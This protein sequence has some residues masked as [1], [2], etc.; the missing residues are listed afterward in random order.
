M[1]AFRAVIVGFVFGISLIFDASAYAK[2]VLCRNLL[3][4]TNLY[5]SETEITNGP[6]NNIQEKG[7]LKLVTFN[8]LQLRMVP[9]EGAFDFGIKS[10]NQIFS[11]A[12][13]VSKTDPDILFLQEV[14]GSGTVSQI[15]QQYWKDAFQ[16]FKT[17]HARGLEIQNVIAVKKNLLAHYDFEHIDFGRTTWQDPNGEQALSPIFQREPL[18]VTMTK[19]SVGPRGPPD[20]VFVNWHLKSQKDRNGDP[21]SRFYRIKQVEALLK[22]HKDLLKMFPDAVIVHGGDFNGSLR[23]DPALN[24]LHKDLSDISDV[25][26]SDKK[27]SDNYSNVY[28]PNGADRIAY[29]RIDGFFIP[30]EYRDLAMG[31]GAVPLADENGNFISKPTRTIDL[32]NMAS[33]HRPQA[34]LIKLR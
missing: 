9:D 11:I 18:V 12:Q 16:T 8:T 1:T 7:S 28:H 34:I 4:P 14:E 29:S 10:K 3:E 21:G 31:A 20:Y 17:T 24:I 13:T 33:D 19:K 23:N 26:N 30:L 25:F 32:K 27:D 22:F 15:S 6:I 2:S 5:S